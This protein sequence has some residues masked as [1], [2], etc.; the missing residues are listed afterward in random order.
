MKQKLF[1][2]LLLSV[3]AGIGCRRNNPIGEPPT[4]AAEKKWVVTTI[5]G[6][7]SPF[8]ADGPSLM[9]KFRAPQDVAV[10]E[11]GIIYVADAL[12]HRIRKI[13]EGQVT[14]FAGLG[15]ED[16]TSGIGI[17]AGFA[18]PFQLATDIAGNLYTLDVHDFRVRKINPYALVTVVAGNGIRGFAEG[19][20]FSAEFGETLGIVT[21]E[22]GNIY[23]T[24]WEN[25]R[26]RKISVTGQVTTVAG[27]GKSGFVN[28]NG[29]T[30]Q[31]ISLGGIVIDKQGNLFVAD[32]NRIRKITP[33]GV[34][35]TF[36]GSDLAG[37]KDGQV[38]VAQFKFIED[39]V[40]DGQGSIY[41]SDDNR[42]RKISIQGEVSTIA[43]STAGYLDGDGTSAKFNGA[44][45]LGIDKQGNIY[46]A[47]VNNS[48][49]RKISFQ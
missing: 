2:F 14:T 42:I 20:A 25:R 12:N 39:M 5:A 48:R 31:F 16:T 41:V 28:G 13:V 44:F 7:G 8:F 30:A 27:N 15:V 21:D 24:D 10:T 6:E 34:V 23:V 29:D 26:V 1:P 17:A 22:Q 32:L 36:A 33:T 38:D 35:S 40:I 37:Y 9:A 46:V 18:L 45:G 49:I 43:G 4:A 47:D 19:N 11:G 3:I